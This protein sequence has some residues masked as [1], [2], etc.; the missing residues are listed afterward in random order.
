MKRNQNN[1][2]D[3]L[4]VKY[5]LGEATDQ[6]VADVGEWLQASTDNRKQFENFKLIWDKSRQLAEISTVDENAAWERFKT[7]IETESAKQ[8]KT[9]NLSTRRNVL[10]AAAGL[11]V[12][13]CCSWFIYYSINRN[14][15]HIS[16]RSTDDVLIQVLPDGSEIVLNKHSAI[17]YKRNF[18][19]DTRDVILDGEAFFKVTPNKTKPFVVSI[20]DV[21]VQVVGTSFNIKSTEEKT[22]V[23]VETGVVEV[24]KN[25][26]E[27]I[28]NP[29]EKATVANTADRP[30]KENN[31]DDL[32]N[33][34]RT[35]EFVCN[36]T[37][38][39]RLVDVLN[40]A[41][42]VNIIIGNERI[43]NLSLTT[44]F[45]NEPVENILAVV[46]ETLHINAEKKG[47]DFILK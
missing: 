35:R 32:Y 13:I 22:E 11:L 39:W 23:I 28:L 12:L 40:E 37:P 45:K 4:L 6:E 7:R 2:T 41:Y 8:T 19:G 38:L 5:L 18:N 29:N 14:N 30:L 16:L 44:T 43:K 42:G 10:Q 25:D 1:I 17:K 3:E 24:E 46:C 31:N 9:I 33:Y 47:S 15:Q 26:H 21:T 27:V 36:N 34:Y 20:N